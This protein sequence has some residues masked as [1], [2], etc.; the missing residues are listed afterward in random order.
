M[1]T[2]NILK[3]KNIK[4]FLT[5]HQRFYFLFLF[6]PLFSFAASEGFPA[7]EI[8][9]QLFN[10]SV[11]VAVFIF[12]VR[13]PVKVFF[14]K[15]QEEFFSFEKQAIQ[16]E[17]ERQTE[18]QS[19]EKKLE[20][21]KKQEAGIKQKA[22]AEGEKFISGKKEEIKKLK[23][24]LKKEADFFL[25][26]ERGKLKRDLFKKWKNKV[27]EGAHLELEKQAESLVFQTE[28][29]KDFFK[30]MEARL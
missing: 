18:N 26:L 1:K 20:T 25:H 11:F 12:L 7:R 6:F 19:W 24:R 23:T 22:Q 29:T 9:I 14:H 3:F 13:K 28:R 16:L 17:K 30:Q 8:L 5:F 10:F 2:K 4:L 15:R 21:L 27:I